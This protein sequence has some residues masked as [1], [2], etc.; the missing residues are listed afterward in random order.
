[1]YKSIRGRKSVPTLYEEKL[2]GE[3]VIDKES[4]ES[5]RSKYLNVLENHLVEAK[6]YTPKV[7]CCINNED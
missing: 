3:G 6:S 2:V 7:I 4:I 1:M 5:F